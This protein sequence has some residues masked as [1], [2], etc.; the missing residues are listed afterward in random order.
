MNSDEIK[1]DLDKWR[2]MPCSWIRRLNIVEMSLLPKLIWRFNIISIKIQA[3]FF[4][5]NKANS[6]IYVE[7]QRKYNSQNN[8]EREKQTWSTDTDL[9]LQDSWY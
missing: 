2:E 5:R 3:G 9:K 8:F 1:D 7:I 4:C 6:K